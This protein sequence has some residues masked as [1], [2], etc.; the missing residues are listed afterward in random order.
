MTFTRLSRNGFAA[1]FLLGVSLALLDSLSVDIADGP[2]DKDGDVRTREVTTS[3]RF[4]AEAA[5]ASSVAAVSGG[6]EK[7][8]VDPASRKSRW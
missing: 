2:E 6:M 4:R 7:A 3:P 8:E 5:A 1:V